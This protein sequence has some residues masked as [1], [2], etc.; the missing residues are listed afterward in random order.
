MNFTKNLKVLA[1]FTGGVIAASLPVFADTETTVVRT[2]SVTSD[3]STISLPTTSTYLLFDPVTGNVR[4]NFDPTRGLTEV[5]MVQSGLVIINQETGKV[6]GTVDANGR[7]IDVTLAPAFDPLVAAIDTRRADL[8]RMITDALGKGTINADQAS[9]LRADLNKLQNEEI[10][11]RQSG[12][13]FTYSEALSI[14]LSLNSLGDRLVPYSQTCA[15]T[16]LLGARIV[17]ANG[18]LVMVDDIEYRKLQLQQRIDD[19]YTAGRLSTQQVASLKEQLN[20]AASLETKYRK[21]GQLS[22][23]KSEKLSVK[24]DSVKTKLDQDV[25]NINDKRAKLGLKVD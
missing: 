13:V 20:A 14:A 3:G 24:L 18:Q 22:A 12:G 6:V 5:P 10:T 11:A 2:T 15:V 23:S 17:N 9:L 25:A 19:E 16:P 1:L 8:E 7:P 21:N 4:G